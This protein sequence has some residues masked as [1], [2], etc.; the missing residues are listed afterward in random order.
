MSGLLSERI[1]VNTCLCRTQTVRAEGISAMFGGALAP[2]GTK[3][4]TISVS[5]G[6]FVTVAFSP[7]NLVMPVKH[8]IF[9]EKGRDTAAKISADE[10]IKRMTELMDAEKAQVFSD[11][12]RPHVKSM[13]VAG[14][15]KAAGF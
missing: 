11:L 13:S 4:D 6:N 10:C 3:V 12:M 1:K 8:L 2:K 5:N 14:T 15:V 9:F 7:N